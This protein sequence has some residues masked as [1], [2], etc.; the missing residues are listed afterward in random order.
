[1]EFGSRCCGDDGEKQKS[2]FTPF[3]MDM[4]FL[5]LNENDGNN[6]VEF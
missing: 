3:I 2:E 6:P 4:L 5:E 1:M